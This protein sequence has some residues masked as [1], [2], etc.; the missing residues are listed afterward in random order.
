[1]LQILKRHLS[2]FDLSN[3][4]YLY[5]FKFRSRFG[6]VLACPSMP[7]YL[8]LMIRDIFDTKH[9][10]MHIHNVTMLHCAFNIDKL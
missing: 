1:M 10:L 2:K 3:I 5:K 4:I 8:F 9:K 7:I 6:L